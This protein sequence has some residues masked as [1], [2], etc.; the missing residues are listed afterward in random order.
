MLWRVVRQNIEVEMA[1]SSFSYSVLLFDNLHALEVRS[2]ALVKV[3]YNTRR[4]TPAPK[5][6]NGETKTRLDS[7][8]RKC[9]YC[10]NANSRKVIHSTKE[11]I[12]R[13]S[14]CNWFQTPVVLMD[15][16]SG[17]VCSCQR[18]NNHTRGL[19]VLGDWRILHRIWVP[20]TG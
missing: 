5:F 4:A 9:S 16:G 17:L 10:S 15:N 19:C 11:S 14:T 8:W 2:I 18:E 20:T 12:W 7:C 13:P 6:L 1:C 3:Q